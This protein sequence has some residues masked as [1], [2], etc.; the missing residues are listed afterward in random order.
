LRLGFVLGCEADIATLDAMAGPWAV[1]GAA[2]EIGRRALCDRNWGADTTARLAHDSLRLDDLAIDA[3]W[4][5]VGGTPLFRL[6]DT[7]DANAAQKRLAGVRIW[8]R[9][10]ANR[11][12]WLRLGLPGNETEWAR[13]AALRP[14]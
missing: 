7:G 8:S 6:Y 13:L 3:G 10:F 11:P 14:T 4:K 9:V 12:G 1:S 2:I 5:L